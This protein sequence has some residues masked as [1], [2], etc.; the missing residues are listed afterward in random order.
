MRRPPPRPPRLNPNP[1]RARPTAHTGR[2]KA[3]FA[4][5][6]A[7]AAGA[8]QVPT[9]AFDAR[10]LDP[11]ALAILGPYEQRFSDVLAVQ[12]RLT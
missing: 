1:T 9:P 6:A 12:V 3:T 7:G 5:V 4:A 2:A 10:R 8:Q 11:R